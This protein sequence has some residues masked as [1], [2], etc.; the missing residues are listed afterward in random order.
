MRV[1]RLSISN[2]RGIK[3]AEIH[4]DG[5]TL[6]VGPNNVGKSTILEA[7]DLVLG[8][9][10]LSRFPPVEEFDFHNATY[11]LPPEQ[12]G[13]EPRIVPIQIEAVVIDLNAELE[14]RCGGHIEFWKPV[15]RRLLAEGKIAEANPPETVSCLRLVTI[16]RYVP[17]EDEF[18]AQTWFAH[19]PDAPDGEL[20]ATPIAL[21]A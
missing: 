7:L 16:A 17:D 6:L 3:S 12:D 21:A 5:H 14:N 1:V 13:E 11:F 2:F 19:S 20:D 8:P 18:E 10:R 4:F 15:D 9:D